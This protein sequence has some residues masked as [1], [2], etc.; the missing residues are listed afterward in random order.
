MLYIV[1]SGMLGFFVFDCYRIHSIYT[2]KKILFITFRNFLGIVIHI[3][4]Y[5]AAGIL[6]LFVN[7]D[8]VSACCGWQ[9]MPSLGQDMVG[10]LV[11][12]FGI[13][14]AGPAGL[15]KSK[16]ARPAHGDQAFD[17]LATRPSGKIMAYVN[18]L[19]MRS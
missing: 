12:G 3:S 13:G 2:K 16:G 4:V 19:L 11:R 8:T 6:A 10:P 9:W 14:L 1:F 5:F 15:S 18:A 7:L 17:D